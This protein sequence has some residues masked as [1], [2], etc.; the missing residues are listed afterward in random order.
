MLPIDG[1]DAVQRLR[2]AVDA[3]CLVCGGVIGLCL[4][5][6]L[7]GDKPIVLTAHRVLEQTLKHTVSLLG[8]FAGN[9]IRQH[10]QTEGG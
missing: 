10:T 1:N 7:F 5:D 4:N 9:G 2:N 3:E 6:A 8:D